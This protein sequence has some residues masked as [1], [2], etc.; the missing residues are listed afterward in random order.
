MVEIGKLADIERWMGV[1][2]LQSAHQKQREADGIDPMRD[3]HRR[4]VAAIPALR[5]GRIVG[6]QI[7]GGQLLGRHGG[8]IMLRR[9]GALPARRTYF[10]C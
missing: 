5:D 10:A 7:L 3:T 1:E 2:D 8:H 4:G 9:S 6:G